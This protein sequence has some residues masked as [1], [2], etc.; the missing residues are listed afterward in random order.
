MLG[1]FNNKYFVKMTLKDKKKEKEVLFHGKIGA[2]KDA[3]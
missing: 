2:S 1:R 3:L